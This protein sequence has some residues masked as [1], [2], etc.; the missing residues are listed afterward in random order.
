[1]FEIVLQT[2]EKSRKVFISLPYF[3]LIKRLI[4]AL[5]FFDRFFGYET[6]RVR[7]YSP[8]CMRNLLREAGFTI[9]KEYKIGRFWQSI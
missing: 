3:V 1:L 8:N 9:I 2:F 7:F 5:F 4:V 6:S